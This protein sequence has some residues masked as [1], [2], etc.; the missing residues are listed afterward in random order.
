M[1]IT[2]ITDIPDFIEND[3]CRIMVGCQRWCIVFCVYMWGCVVCGEAW[4]AENPVCRFKTPPC[5]RLGRLSVYRQHAR[6]QDHGRLTAVRISKHSLFLSISRSVVDCAHK[7]LQTLQKLQ[8]FIECKI[9]VGWPPCTCPSIR[10]CGVWN[11]CGVWYV[12]F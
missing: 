10:V 8:I 11:V 7:K 6:V 2:D 9:M 3:I 4:H 12:W 1:K 5:V